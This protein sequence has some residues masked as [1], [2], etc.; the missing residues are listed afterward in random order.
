MFKTASARTPAIVLGTGGLIPFVALAFMIYFDPG[1][2]VQWANAL[3]AYGATI[4]AFVGALHWGVAM[5]QTASV[6]Q[7]WLLMGWS[8]APASMGWISLLVSPARGLALLLVGFALHQIV[9]LVVARRER[10]PGWYL[11]LRISLSSVAA[12]SLFA[13]LSAMH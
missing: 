4:L 6:R 12:L 5:M 3:I 9:D 13:A 2:R 7:S 1:G 10:L 8:V 11:P